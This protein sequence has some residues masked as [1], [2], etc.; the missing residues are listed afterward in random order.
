LDVVL[1]RCSLR[2]EC[3]LHTVTPVGIS[4]AT[5]RKSSIASFR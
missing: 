3:C 5:A 2:R 4:K 1:G